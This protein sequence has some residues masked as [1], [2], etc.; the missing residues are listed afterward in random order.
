MWFV[1]LKSISL[2]IVSMIF[3]S[4]IALLSSSNTVASFTMHQDSGIA[5][6][7][8]DACLWS[9][10]KSIRVHIGFTFCF[11]KYSTEFLRVFL[12]QQ[13]FLTV[14]IVVW[15][16]PL[17]C[18]LSSITSFSGVSDW[19]CFGWIVW[20]PFFKTAYDQGPVSLKGL[21][22]GRKLVRLTHLVSKDTTA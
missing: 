20:G 14:W 5:H 19:F 10:S 22:F 1:P 3:F 13:V 12:A 17:S 18:I 21:N 11:L 6:L 16:L 8:S 15:A 4:L 2:S 7:V 9:G